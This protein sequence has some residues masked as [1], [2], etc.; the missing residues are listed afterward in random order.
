MHRIQHGKELYVKKCCSNTGLP[1]AQVYMLALQVEFC[2][3]R[4][5][6]YPSLIAD[7]QHGLLAS[8]IEN[9][10]PASWL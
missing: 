8:L 6:S 5:H 10:Q 3:V 1:C 2:M 4:L 9:M 7:R